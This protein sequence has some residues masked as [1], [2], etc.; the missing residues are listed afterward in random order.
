MGLGLDRR[1]R[2]RNRVI[3]TQIQGAPQEIQI[4]LGGANPIG[5]RVVPSTVPLNL[6]TQAGLSTFLNIQIF[7]S[8]CEI[9]LPEDISRYHDI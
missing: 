6:Y 9:E 7:K 1:S 3:I 8:D 5:V 2:L 4:L